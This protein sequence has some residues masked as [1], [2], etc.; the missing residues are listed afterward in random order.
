VPPGSAE[1]RALVFGDDEF[2]D[3]C[4]EVPT[5]LEHSER[6]VETLNCN[7][8]DASVNRRDHVITF[9]GVLS[10]NDETLQFTEDGFR[11]LALTHAK[12]MSG[13]RLDDWRKRRGREAWPMPPAAD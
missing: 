13:E 7:V 3:T 9:Q 4:E 2:A 11:E 1:L 6:P 12:P 8:V 10:V 5:L